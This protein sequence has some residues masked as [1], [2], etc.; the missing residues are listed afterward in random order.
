MDCAEVDVREVNHA[1]PVKRGRQ[2]SHR[3]RGVRDFHGVGGD[4][5]GVGADAGQEADESHVEGPMHERLVS[6]PR[7]E[8]VA[9][10]LGH[11]VRRN[12][13]DRTQLRVTETGP[14]QSLEEVGG[15]LAHID[16]R[17]SEV[18]AT[19][20]KEQVESTRSFY[21]DLN[22]AIDA[23][24]VDGD[25]FFF[26]WTV[27]GSH[28]KYAKKV[29]LRGVT[30]GQVQDGIIVDEQIVYDRLEEANQLGFTIRS[31]AEL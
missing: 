17:Y 28:R 23:I 15:H 20:L 21:P 5:A 1:K 19:Q 26:R 14:L 8:S 12:P 7:P 3:N 11:P 4:E 27:T 29:E 24:A 18:M 2:V 31:P 22:M 10:E 25:L 6:K 9:P 30:Y 16:E 13:H